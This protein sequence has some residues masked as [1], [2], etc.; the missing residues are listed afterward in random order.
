MDDTE[1][2]QSNEDPDVTETSLDALLARRSAAEKGDG[3]GE[4]ISTDD[5]EPAERLPGK[6]APKQQT[7]FVCKNCRLIKHQSQLAD[8]RRGYC[9]DCAGP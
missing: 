9:R 4:M 6:V 5:H 7:E 2:A 8:K 1:E 3:D